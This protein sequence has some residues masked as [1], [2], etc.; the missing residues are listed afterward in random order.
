MTGESDPSV[1]DPHS[2]RL[3]LI[4]SRGL[5][6]ARHSAIKLSVSSRSE[7]PGIPQGL[8]RRTTLSPIVIG[9]FAIMRK[10][11]EEKKNQKIKE[12]LSFRRF[13]NLSNQTN[14]PVVQIPRIC[15][16]DSTNFNKINK[17][18]HGINAH[19]CLI[20]QNGNY[21]L[22]RMSSRIA[23]SNNFVFF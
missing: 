19:V 4:R 15:S 18:I 14:T 22:K 8:D 7:N 23:C 9:P 20:S 21:T 5:V 17:H 1:S 6:H 12:N 2:L 16:I 10:N 3:L 13:N 11:T